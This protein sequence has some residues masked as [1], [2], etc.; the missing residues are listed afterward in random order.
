MVIYK[1]IPRFLVVFTIILLAFSISFYIALKAGDLN[2]KRQ[3]E[4][5]F[6]FFNL[7]NMFM[8][9]EPNK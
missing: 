9:D 1:D 3:V 4:S 5:E 7:S 8:M 2:L 6:F